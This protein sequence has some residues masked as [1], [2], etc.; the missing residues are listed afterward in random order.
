M[1]VVPAGDI[2]IMWLA[3][4]WDEVWSTLRPPQTSDLNRPDRIRQAYRL[5]LSVKLGRGDD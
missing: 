3:E 4:E 1:A 2:D 5:T